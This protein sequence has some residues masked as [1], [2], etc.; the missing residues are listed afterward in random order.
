[1]YIL[2]VLDDKLQSTVFVEEIFQLLDIKVLKQAHDVSRPGI[3][4]FDQHGKK[5]KQL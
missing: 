1:M 5:N 2:R 4:G 3:V